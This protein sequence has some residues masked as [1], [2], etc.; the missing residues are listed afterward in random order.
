MIQHTFGLMVKPSSE[1]R[2]IAKLPAVSG[3][4]LLSTGDPE[5]LVQAIDA[6]GLR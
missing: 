1:W 5:L 3:I 2:S 6:S 4:H